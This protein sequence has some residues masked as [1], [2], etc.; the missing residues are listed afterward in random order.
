MRSASKPTP[1][2]FV[3]TW[4]YHA[5]HPDNALA[6]Y[7]L[8]SAEGMMGNRTKE[9]LG[10]RRE[11]LNPRHLLGISRRDCE[12]FARLI[13]IPRVVRCCLMER[14][15]FSQRT[16]K[17]LNRPGSTP[18]TSQTSSKEKGPLPLSWKIQN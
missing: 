10:Y 1:R 11:R 14:L 17:S 9:E 18:N 3:F 5:Q 8:G 15:S 12:R 6:H 4:K 7:R 13:G 16:I 2:R